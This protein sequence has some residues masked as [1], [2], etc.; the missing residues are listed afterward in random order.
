MIL[1]KIYLIGCLISFTLLA[2]FVAAVYWNQRKKN[3]SQTIQNDMSIK[4]N[5]IIKYLLL[6]FVNIA[7]KDLIDKF[8]GAFRI[9]LVEKY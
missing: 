4:L 3:N 1:L 8:N 7:D 2:T 9:S 6:Q 5:K